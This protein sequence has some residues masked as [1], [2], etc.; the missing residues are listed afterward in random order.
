MGGTRL[1]LKITAIYNHPPGA[2]TGVYVG[3]ILL[4]EVCSKIQEN[5]KMIW[6][7]MPRDMTSAPSV[8]FLSPGTKLS[9][10]QSNNHFFVGVG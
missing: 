2:F 1:T 5:T 3:S 4:S 9:P 10:C 8:C 7:R 6:A